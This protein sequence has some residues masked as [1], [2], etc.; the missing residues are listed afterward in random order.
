MGVLDEIQFIERAVRAW[1]EKKTFSD[2]PPGISS[3]SPSEPPPSKPCQGLLHGKG[4]LSE[5]DPGMADSEK[6]TQRRRLTTYGII[7]MVQEGNYHIVMAAPNNVKLMLCP[8]CES[9]KFDSYLYTII[10]SDL[11]SRENLVQREA[12]WEALG[13]KTGDGPAD[14]DITQIL[15]YSRHYT[16]LTLMADGT[17]VES[18]PH[19]IVDGQT[20]RNLWLQHELK[21]VDH[22]PAAP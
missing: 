5:N 21:Y 15:Y 2:V 3:G 17:F 19:Y 13:I 4:S 1:M 14:Y 16:L 8:E 11:C 12:A 10:V 18:H 9:G 22:S 7:N 6:K 20:E